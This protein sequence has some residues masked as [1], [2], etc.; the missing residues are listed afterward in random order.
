MRIGAVLLKEVHYKRAGVSVTRDEYRVEAT[1]KEGC[2]RKKK[3]LMNWRAAGEFA[4]EQNKTLEAIKGRGAFTF[5]DAAD[6]WLKVQEQRTRAK[7]PDLSQGVLTNRR[8]F[9]GQLQKRFGRTLLHRIELADLEDWLLEQSA[10]NKRATLRVKAGVAYF[11]L[12]HARKRKM[13]KVNPL[14]GEKLRYPGEDAQR[15]EIPDHSDMDKLR[16]YLIGA[17]GRP[18]PRPFKVNRLTWSSMRVAV[19]L[20]ATCGL[21]RGEVCGLRWDR[22]NRVQEMA[23]VYIREVVTERRP[24][25]R[26]GRRRRRAS[27]RFRSRS[28]SRR[29]CPSTARSTSRSSASA[30]AMWFASIAPRAAYRSSRRRRSRRRSGGSCRVPGSSTRTAGRGSRSML[31]DTTPRPAGSCITRP[32]A[33][34]CRCRNGSGTGTRG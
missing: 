22:I 12:E 25:S 6:A 8:L 27:A 16:E 13:L 19:V 28:R 2:T 30:S 21:R 9:A 10:R 26:T 18:A 1:W 32:W 3:W 34:S 24:R 29:S 31:C 15:I 5:N 7:T 20:G 14:K 17:H 33:A 11:I 4:A 23:E